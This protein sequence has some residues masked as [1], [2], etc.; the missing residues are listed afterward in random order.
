MT[1]ARELDL[2]DHVTLPG[3]MA[4][5]IVGTVVGRSN[6]PYPGPDGG[7]VMWMVVETDDG[8]RTKYVCAPDAPVTV[9]RQMCPELR[10]TGNHDFDD[11]AV[12]D[13]VTGRRCCACG[14]LQGSDSAPVS[15]YGPAP[16]HLRSRG[17]RDPARGLV[18]R[19]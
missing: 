16:A 1:V 13:R 14:R 8:D 11:V 12:G 3:L 7:Q 10:A 17:R 15:S 18:D 9:N 19:P 4:A 5:E 2:G 6:G